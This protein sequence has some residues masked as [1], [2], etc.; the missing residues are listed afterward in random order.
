MPNVLSAASVMMCAHGG[1]CQPIAISPR[2]KLS[3]SPCLIVG[4]PMPIAGCPIPPNMGVPCTMAQ[5]ALGSARV[6]SMGQAVLTL[7]STILATPSGG[8]VSI[9]SAGQTR[10]SAA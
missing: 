1:R 3:G 4:T 9:A 2:V 6:R 7:S 8:P 10:V 5:A